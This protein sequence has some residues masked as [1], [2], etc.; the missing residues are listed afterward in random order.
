MM[1]QLI[2]DTITY[3]PDTGLFKWLDNYRK[4]AKGWFKGT[5]TNKYLEISINGKKYYTHRLAWYLMYGRFPKNFIDHKNGIP[6]DNR[7][8]NLREATPLQ[9]NQNSTGRGASFNKQA[10]KWESRISVNKKDLF[11]GYFATEEEA[12]QAYV[13]GK[14]KYHPFWIEKE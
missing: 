8:S 1:Q 10:K 2:E 4:H 13:K 5:S 6:T 9:N 12:H 14:K 3:D 11:L 7:L